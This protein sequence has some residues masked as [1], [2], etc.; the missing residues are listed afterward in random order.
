MFLYKLLIFVCLSIF[1]SAAFNIPLN[2]DITFDLVCEFSSLKLRTALQIIFFLKSTS[3]S[4]AAFNNTS[5]YIHAKCVSTSN[6]KVELQWLLHYVYCAKV[7]F[8]KEHD[9]FT[10]PCSDKSPQSEYIQSEPI[11]IECTPEGGL[12]NFQSE[13]FSKPLTYKMCSNSSIVP[14]S[15]HVHDHAKKA[16]ENQALVT[17][18]KDG[19]YV[20][21]MSVR[22]ADMLNPNWNISLHLAVRDSNGN[23]LSAID[24][25]FLPFW[26]V[27]CG[28]YALLAIV[29]LAF[30]AYYMRDLLRVQIWIGAV[31]F[32][33][34]IESA[35]YLGEV[36]SI[37]KNGVLNNTTVIAAE[38]VSALKRSLARMLVI[39]VSLG[40]GIVKPQLGPALP[41]VIIFGVCYFVTASIYSVVNLM[42]VRFETNAL[43]AAIPV[44]VVDAVAAWW[45]F[46]SLVETTR[47]LRMRRNITKLSLYKHFI[48]I[49]AL[50]LL[51]AIAFMV[52]SIRFKQFDR[53]PE[54]SLWWIEDAYWPMLFTVILMGIC[55]LWR[56]SQN[57]QRYAFSPLRDCDEEEDDNLV[58]TELYGNYT[59]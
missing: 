24:W 2:E 5:V 4:F 16:E 41:K 45:V 22:S 21:A 31:I 14:N 34:M 52:W 23:Y 37:N 51:A 25:P 13:Q 38:L 57:N 50:C 20:L 19:V 36:D 30:C 42:S 48:N 6:Q 11:T 44:S 40:Y 29:W 47:F 49:L 55:I 12:V 26:G 43:F 28:C 54:W 1:A 3:R 59:L 7:A 56:P 18:W 35:V 27:M 58:V 17:T 33:G 8:M 32:L 15:T 46:S 9:F 53:C 10:N 39:I